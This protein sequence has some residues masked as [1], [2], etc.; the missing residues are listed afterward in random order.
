MSPDGLE[1]HDR[2][3]AG[4]QHGGAAPLWQTTVVPGATTV[5]GGTTIVCRGGEELLKLRQ[6]PSPSTSGRNS[7]TLT[8]RI[9]DL[10]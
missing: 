1:T 3:M 6:P 5:A 4:A 7:K 8:I 9:Q 10:Q 2:R